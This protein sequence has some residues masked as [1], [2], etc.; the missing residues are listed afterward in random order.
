P[1]RTSRPNR[2]RK[3][4]RAKPPASNSCQHPEQRRAALQPPFLLMH[5]LV[6]HRAQRRTLS[7][8][9][10]KRERG[11][12]H[13][14]LQSRFLF[15]AFAGEASTLSFTTPPSAAKSAFRGE[16]R[17]NARP[18]LRPGCGFCRRRNFT[19]SSRRSTSAAICGI[20]VTP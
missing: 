5:I 14:H 8:L 6:T 1:A 10:R 12:K 13:G 9:S 16:V 18:M 3:R 4:R 20:S 7:P 15:A 11:K 2:R 17:R 19:R